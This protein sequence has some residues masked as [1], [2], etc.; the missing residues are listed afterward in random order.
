MTE[1]I[2]GALMKTE[3]GEEA[4]RAQEAAEEEE[5][6]RK[7]LKEKKGKRK[8]W[9]ARWAAPVTATSNRRGQTAPAAKRP[10]ETHPVSSHRR[11]GRL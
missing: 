6:K 2:D 8:D 5:D 11:R 4:K 7:V 3:K 10:R 1:T 9:E